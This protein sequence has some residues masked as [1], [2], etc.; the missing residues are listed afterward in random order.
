MSE[1][2]P[3][4]IALIR[5]HRRR[6]ETVYRSEASGGLKAGDMANR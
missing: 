2:I 3:E 4:L 1:R 6:L 5:A